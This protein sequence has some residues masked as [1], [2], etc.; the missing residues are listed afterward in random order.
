M[1]EPLFIADAEKALKKKLKRYK[2]YLSQ[3]NRVKKQMCYCDRC[4][5]SRCLEIDN[6]KRL[7]RDIVH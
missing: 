5:C 2:E 1:S 4:A 3:Y 7:M 6:L